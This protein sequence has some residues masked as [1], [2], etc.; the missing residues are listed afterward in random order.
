MTRRFRL[1]GGVCAVA[2][3]VSLTAIDSGFFQKEKSVVLIDGWWSADTAQDGCKMV[4]RVWSHWPVFFQP[5]EE[6]TKRHEAC[7]LVMFGPDGPKNEARNFETRLMTQF[8]ALPACKGITVAAYNG[9]L[10]KNSPAV[11]EL[12]RGSFWQLMIDY[13]VGETIQHWGMTSPRMGLHDAEGD[14][15][16]IA[17][18]VCTIVLGHGASVP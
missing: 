15:T 1:Y 3:L 13:R 10:A 2:F 12:S 18:D 17:R 6:T 8:A 14:L 4:E 16:K 7:R 5:D 11:M 9:P